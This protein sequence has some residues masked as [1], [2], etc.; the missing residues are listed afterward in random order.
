MQIVIDINEHL[1]KTIKTLGLVVED[2]DAVAVSEA[3]KNSTPLPKGHGRLIDADALID[4]LGCSDRDIYVEAC[5]EEDAPTIIGAYKAESEGQWIDAEV[6]DK[7]RAEI[8]KYEDDCRL[9]VDE[10]PSCKQCTDNT[11]ET[12]YAILDKYKAESKGGTQHDG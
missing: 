11:F 7:I 9:S 4:T 10:Y 1:Y 2:G 5:I 6:I 12:I 8:I 3:I